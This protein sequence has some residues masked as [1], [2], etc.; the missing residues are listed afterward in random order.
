M[1]EV[2]YFDELK[3]GFDSY[4]RVMNNLAVSEAVRERLQQSLENDQRDAVD[5]RRWARLRISNGKVEVESIR[6]GF[7]GG[8]YRLV[9]FNQDGRAESVLYF[10]PSDEG[11]KRTEQKMLYGFDDK[12]ELAFFLHLIDGKG[13]NSFLVREQNDYVE[14]KDEARAKKLMDEAMDRARLFRCE[15]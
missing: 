1:T 2:C 7:K 12:E 3:V 8:A 5:V 6:V 13:I 11:L 15:K 14:S 10:T 4:E 9:R